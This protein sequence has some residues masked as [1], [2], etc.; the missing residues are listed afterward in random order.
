MINIPLTPVVVLFLPSVLRWDMVFLFCSRLL[1]DCCKLARSRLVDY[2]L[3]LVH[4]KTK[5]IFRYNG[6]SLI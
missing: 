2:F 5:Y 6:S 3:S 4:N 1:R